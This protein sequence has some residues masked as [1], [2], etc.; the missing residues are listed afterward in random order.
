MAAD[1][2][3]RWD[4]A[5]R[6][7]TRYLFN[8]T[9]PRGSGTGWV[10]AMSPADDFCAIATAAHVIEHAH[11]WEFPIRL[12]HADSSRQV[13]V[14]HGERTFY[15]DAQSDTAVIILDTTTLPIG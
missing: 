2:Q 14:P 11:Q 10:V 6:Q 8:I 13:L 5:V 4:E 9:T 1:S 3:M 15:V 7:V 12:R